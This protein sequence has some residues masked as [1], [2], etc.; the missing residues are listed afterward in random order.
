MA[1]RRRTRGVAA[2]AGCA[3]TAMTLGACQP[4]GPAP[5][6]ATESLASESGNATEPPFD[7]RGSLRYGL[8]ADPASIDPRFVAD[9]EGAT[10]V[11]ALFDS[12]TALDDDLA[13]EPSAATSFEV[14]G[15][16][17]RF[18]FELDED[19]RFHD[20]TP[21]TAADFVRSFRRIA[22]G[23]A[24]PPS[25]VSY[26][27]D[28]VE[29]FGVAQERGGRL[30]GVEAVDRH[31]L[32]IRL[33]YPFPELPQVL[34]NP[35]LAPI[36]PVAVED[37][38]AF[39]E[40][41]IG[42]GPFRMSAPWQHDQFIRVGR[43]E[44]HPGPP[45]RL[46]EVVFQ[47]YAGEGAVESQWTELREGLL[48]V[49]EV[50]AD[51]LDEAAAQFGRSEDGYTGPGLLDGA[52]TTLYYYGFNTS[53]APFDDVRVRRALSLLIDRRRI[54]Q[55]LL[56]G[57][58]LA[59]ES[60]V[61]P[62]VPGSQPGACDHCRYAPDEARALIEDA[63]GTDVL[64]QPLALVHNE[65]R[66][67]EAIAE[68]IAA[69]VETALDIEVE[70]RADGLGPYLQSVREGEV[71]VFRL[72]WQADAPSPGNYLF[73][74]FHAQQVGQDNLSRYDVP[75]VSQLLATA[76]GT[77]EQQDRRELWQAAERR[78]LADAPVAPVFFY[79]HARV[80][81]PEVVGLHL[82][83][84]GRTDLTRVALGGG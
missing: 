29:G 23:T 11:D 33:R 19:A 27:L 51:S 83:A 82:D 77:V 31:T 78:I 3:L 22:D 76:R 59:A 44:R 56:G 43:A 15:D 84:L 61:A 57:A 42:N 64:P 17:T 73:P 75:E 45:S 81:R 16:A 37:P 63:G 52:T 9:D 7:A 72:G 68:R 5:E 25:Y 18:V 80:V 39:A 20:G 24:Q 6:G 70:T 14:N 26:L 71:G 48:H 50:P 41:P 38:E 28:P 62:P 8:S 34:A 79:R 35:S 13:V 54:A 30:R 46:D 40:R 60:I 65:G 1:G 2:V 69:D 67:H 74:M 21:V 36:P 47:I 66:T 49:G 58:R 32:E 10:V 53:Q 4:P 55:D 12:L